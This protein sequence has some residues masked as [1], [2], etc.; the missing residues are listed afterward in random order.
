MVL[1]GLTPVLRR[2]LFK[3]V[4]IATMDIAGRLGTLLHQLI[5]V[6]GED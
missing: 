6:G 4:K 5:Q 3:P 2:E 1:A